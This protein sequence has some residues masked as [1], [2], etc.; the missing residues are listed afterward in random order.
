[1]SSKIAGKELDFTRDAE[2]RIDVEYDTFTNDQRELTILFDDFTP[3]DFEVPTDGSYYYLHNNDDS[4]EFQFN[5]LA[6]IEGNDD[7]SEL[8]SFI[9]EWQGDGAGTSTVIIAGG[10]ISEES[11]AE[12]DNRNIKQLVN[13][14]CWNDSYDRVYFKQSVD[15]TDDSTEILGEE[16]SVD[17]CVFD[18]QDSTDDLS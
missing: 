1:M 14:E 15:F 18:C 7:Q 13:C 11:H 8:F 5:F 4:G 6:D 3:D 9:T 10:D 12:F 17:D 2:G 16:G